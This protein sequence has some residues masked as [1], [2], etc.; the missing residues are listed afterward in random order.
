MQLCI[1]ICFRLRTEVGL[2]IVYSTSSRIPLLKISFLFRP[3]EWH[4][5]TSN[6]PAYAA[7]GGC[8]RRDFLTSSAYSSASLCFFGWSPTKEW[9][10]T[11]MR[12]SFLRNKDLPCFGCNFIRTSLIFVSNVGSHSPI[13]KRWKNL[14]VNIP[15]I[16]KSS[17]KNRTWSLHLQGFI[18]KWPRRLVRKMMFCGWLGYVT[19]HAVEG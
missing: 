3:N 8:L 11:C 10:A 7:G 6:M 2:M 14:D 17:L 16:W 15:R 5:Y 12:N 9:L 19:C 18:T 1:S 13:E 4:F